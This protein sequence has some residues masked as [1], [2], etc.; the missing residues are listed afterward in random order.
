MGKVQ[1]WDSP[2][3]VGAMSN[4][5]T[6]T[7]L[8][9][10]PVEKGIIYV[11]TDDG[12]VQVTE[13]H[14]ETWRKVEVGRIS[15]VPKTAFVNDIKADLYNA[16]TVYM[17]LDNHKYGDFKPYLVKSTDRGRTW[18]SIANNIPDR[19]LVWRLVQDHVEPNLLFAG[20]EYGIYF[21]IDGGGKWIKLS[22]TPTISF[23]DL[24]IQKR[25]NDLVGAS[26]GRSFYVLDDY[27]CLREISKEKLNEDAALFSTRKAWWYSP[28]YAVTGIGANDYVAKNPDFGA[29]FTYYLKDDFTT[30]QSERKKKE[31]ELEKANRDVPFPGW[32][33]LDAE[34]EEE[35]A[36]ILLV[37]KDQAGNI[38]RSLK[39]KTEKGIH[40]TAW[41]LRYT[42]KRNIGLDDK[43]NRNSGF[44]ASPGTY[45]VTLVQRI[46]GA[47]TQLAGPQSFEVVPLRKGTLEG[48]SIAEREAFRKD[49][50]TLQSEVGATSYTMNNS[51][52]RIQ[53]MQKALGRSEQS[54]PELYQQLRQ[55]KLDLKALQKEM[56]GSPAKEEI[57]ERNNPTVRSRMWSGFRALNNTYGPT[58][59]HKK[60]IGV[61]KKQLAS[62]KDKL[63]SITD[64]MPQLEQALRALGAPWVEG[65]PLPKE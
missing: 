27:S 62:V 41:D 7:S 31:K 65:Q 33:A 47:T 22:G 49:M 35:K 2:W 3:D 18:K 54:S 50:E 1:S 14:G 53:A 23:R 11:G 39:G 5:N 56:N 60:T 12:I 20:T 32:D 55:A 38:V 44:L 42:S 26:F 37:V 29:V 64:L 21:T 36:E 43:S 46:N 63:T 51:M 45:T 19:T 8:G 10:S 9:V 59:N 13:N 24:A 17:A 40:R 25:E 4:F 61:A 48:A 16:N 28:R 30:A 58:P 52:K 6:I 34:N 57:G 15:G